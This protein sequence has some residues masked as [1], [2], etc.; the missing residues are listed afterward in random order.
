MAAFAATAL[1]KRDSA[2]FSYGCQQPGSASRFA[3]DRIDAVGASLDRVL[4]ID[5][6]CACNGDNGI[7]N[8]FGDYSMW[9]TVAALSDRAIFIDW[10]FDS[11]DRP[12]RTHGCGCKRAR[13]RFDLGEHY[14]TSAG[15][16]WRWTAAARA[17][18]ARRHG[19]AGSETVVEVSRSRSCEEVTSLLAG[20]AP[21]LTLIA[22]VGA[23]S[24]A[25]TPFCSGA[26]L[27]PTNSGDCVALSSPSQRRSCRAKYHA[28][29][30]GGT[31]DAAKGPTLRRGERANPTK[32]Y[33]TEGDA[34]SLVRAFALRWSRSRGLEVGAEGAAAGPEV[35]PRHRKDVAGLVQTLGKHALWSTPVNSGTQSLPLGQLMRCVLHAM[36]R[37]QPPLAVRLTALAELAA[38]DALVVLQLRTGWADDTEVLAGAAGRWLPSLKVAAPREVSRARGGRF[39]SAGGGRGGGRVASPPVSSASA[40]PA[41]AMWSALTSSPCGQLPARHGLDLD[42]CAA[43]SGPFQPIRKPVVG[44]WTAQVRLV[45]AP[46]RQRRFSA[47]QR[48]GGQGGTPASS[49]A[50][51]SGSGGLGRSRRVRFARCGCQ[52]A[53]RPSSLFWDSNPPS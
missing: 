26:S 8:L 49:R 23:D 31:G 24:I 48:P 29:N 52:A 2:R 14:Q 21:W 15:R 10:V 41:A 37:P 9:F 1:A 7:G 13:R 53:A 12:N 39:A 36:L 19:G 51:R 50:G 11:P 28:D 44:G 25:M 6:S 38:A 18:V 34:A 17:A 42:R 4:V 3:T 27:Y 46:S 40:S 5:A 30:E 22:V 43:P 35:P 32:L 33:P 16:S 47:P 45:G 20:P